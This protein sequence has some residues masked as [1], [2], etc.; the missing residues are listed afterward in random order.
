MSVGRHDRVRA[1]TAHAVNAAIDDAMRDRLFAYSTCSDEEISA[2]L[3]ALDDEWDIERYLEVLAPGF[4]LAGLA[5]GL[6]RDRRWLILSGGVLAFLLQHAVQGW[7]PPLAVLRRIGVRTRREIDEERYALKALRGD[8]SG[9]PPDAP[10]NR[11]TRIDSVLDA[12]RS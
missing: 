10:R 5:L 2:R 6:V 3:D 9:L 12:V 4:A 8:F 11:V 7:C 1:H